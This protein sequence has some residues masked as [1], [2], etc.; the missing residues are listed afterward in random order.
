MVLLYTKTWNMVDICELRA[1]IPNTMKKMFKMLGKDV[2]GEEISFEPEREGWD[3]Y[4]LEDGTK[5]K[6]K[7]VVTRIDRLDAYRPDGDP[8]YIVHSSNVV[9]LDVPESL[10]KDGS[11]QNR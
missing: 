4:L 2:P 5:L 7:T 6:L 10:K 1:Y 8:V 9:S 3:V 11:S